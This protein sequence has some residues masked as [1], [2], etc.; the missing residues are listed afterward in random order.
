MPLCWVHHIGID[1][2]PSPAPTKLATLS[3]CHGIGSAV[4]PL[5]GRRFQARSMKRP[6][7]Q[8]LFGF[9]VVSIDCIQGVSSFRRFPQ[10]PR[11]VSAPS[12]GRYRGTP[13]IT[14]ATGHN[15]TQRPPRL[16][17]VRHSPIAAVA[18]IIIIIIVCFSF[19]IF[20]YFTRPNQ[21][22]EGGSMYV[23]SHALSARSWYK[24]GSGSGQ[25]GWDERC[26]PTWGDTRRI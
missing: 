7:N 24:T 15:A 13:S 14:H 20:C 11:F 16:C 18:C 2:D 4:Q 23:D 25:A 19:V 17:A 22:W 1:S 12:R 5:I 26:Q 8:L 3:L 10:T 6:F 9:A 21:C